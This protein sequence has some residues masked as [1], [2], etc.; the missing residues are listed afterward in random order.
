MTGTEGTGQAPVPTPQP[1]KPM[2]GYHEGS[3]YRRGKVVSQKTVH[4][5]DDQLRAVKYLRFNEK[6]IAERRAELTDMSW[7]APKSMWNDW[8]HDRNMQERAKNRNPIIRRVRERVA[9]RRSKS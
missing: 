8:F 5:R 6:R 3:H 2:V 7:A 4:R 1:K 9:A